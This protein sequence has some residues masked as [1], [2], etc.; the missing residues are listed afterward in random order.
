M[1]LGRTLT[2][3]RHDG[4]DELADLL[5]VFFTAVGDEIAC[6]DLSGEQRR[7]CH[8]D[9]GFGTGPFAPVEGIDCE[10][11]DELMGRTLPLSGRLLDAMPILGGD[12]GRS[13][14]G[15]SDA[16]CSGDTSGSPS[17]AAVQERLAAAAPFGERR[18]ADTAANPMGR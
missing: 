3:I 9:F 14:G 12:A 17:E 10:F 13:A 18:R 6:E 2:G 7:P 1:S 4:G 5:V 16:S 8:L 11:Y 15:E